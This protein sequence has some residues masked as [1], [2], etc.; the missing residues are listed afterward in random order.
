MGE[1]KL[2]L[3]NFTIDKLLKSTKRQLPQIFFLI[4]LKLKSPIRSKKS[5]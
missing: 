2:D 4:E 1:K 3:K 5:D